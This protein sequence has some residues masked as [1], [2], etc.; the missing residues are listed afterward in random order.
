MKRVTIETASLSYAALV[1]AAASLFSIGLIA[2][3]DAPMIWSVLVACAA[4]VTAAIS[5][6]GNVKAALLAIFLFTLPIEISKALTAQASAYSPAIS[7]YLSDV[8]FFLL[9][10]V[11]FVEKLF[12]QKSRICWSLVHSIAALLLA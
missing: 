10:A 11:W 9:A 4:G 2:A 5:C 12:V 7:L 6:S 3:V 8:P 1:L